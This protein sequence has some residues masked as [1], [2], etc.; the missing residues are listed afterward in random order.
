LTY[1]YPKEKILIKLQAYIAYQK[2]ED[3]H[4]K[5]DKNRWDKSRNLITLWS[6]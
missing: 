5:F 4:F 2:L 1:K 3:H 6:I